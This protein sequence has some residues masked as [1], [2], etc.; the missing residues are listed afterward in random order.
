MARQPAKRLSEAERERIVA[1]KLDRHTTREI[2]KEVGCAI[3]TVTLHWHQWLDETQADR[4]EHLE[5]HRSRLIAQLESA[6][7]LARK[8]A[9]RA[10][11]SSGMDADQRARAEARYLSE[12]RQ[13]LRILSTV[14]GFDAPIRVAAAFDTMTDDEARRILAELDES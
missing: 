1:M 13:A 10:R 4:R 14:A 6:A 9:N 2:A 11:E 3:N 8:G 5:R 12:E 7:A